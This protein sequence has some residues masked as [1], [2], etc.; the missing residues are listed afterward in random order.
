MLKTSVKFFPSSRKEMEALGWENV[1]IILF[2]GDAY[3]DHPAFG[4]A[5]I[6]RVLESHGYRVA[7][8]PQ[9][10]WRD[11]LRDFKKLGEP[12]LFFGVN[13]GAMDSMVNHYTA[14]KRLRSDDAYTP[15]GLAGMRPDYA[16]KTYSNI[17]KDLYPNVPVVVGGIEASL[18]RLS[19]FDYWQDKIL[20][21]ILVDSKADFLIYGMGERPILKLAKFIKENRKN[22]SDKDLHLQKLDLR[23]IAFLSDIPPIVDDNTLVLHSFK[24]CQ[25]DK[26]AF[27]DNFNNIET[28]A[29]KYN[30]KLIVEPIDNSY[31]Y[32][33]PPFD[34][35]SEQE[36]DSFYDL[37]YTKLPHSRYK[38]KHI[39]AYE[40]IKYSI[41][42]HRGCFGGCS[43]CTIA[44]H[45]GK[46][47][48]SRSEQSILNEIRNLMSL[49]G[50]SGNISDVGGPTANMYGMHG[51]DL[52]IC[53]K[54]FR[55]SCLYP[56][57]CN[58]LNPS[59]RRLLKL[60]ASIS[61][62][63]G[64]KN[65]YVGSG[66]RYDLFLNEKGFLD[67]SSKPYFTEL[68]LNHVSGRLKVAPEH[69]EDRVLNLMNKPSFALFERLRREFD[70]L[71]REK[72][73]K[74]Q[75]IPYFISSHPGCKMQDMEKLSRNLSL[76][77]VLTEQVQDFTPTPMT[78]SS[79]M[80]YT[81]LDMKSL[82]KLY[83]EKNLSKK[84]E[85]KSYFFKK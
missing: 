10:N 65:F 53:E 76:K 69:T 75:L 25:K 9:P 33:N 27:I 72:D 31:V 46:Q 21:S 57:M 32:V 4:T 3:I 20:P 64:I 80:Y 73:L 54:C 15:N 60:Y 11:D 44:A 85:Q 17:L 39:P 13:A 55:K 71:T 38:G 58:N 29:N 30:A 61:E 19:H 7:V 8:V 56:K 42:T 50:F 22:I 5:V 78:K 79:V 41:N 24:Q 36:L 37:P 40:M 12:R 49:E 18:R 45:Q 43:F 34:L 68:V 63:K 23:Q 52:S 62:I 59:H 2:S 51:N 47:I 84:K 16:V 48:Q 70:K 82:E 81:E 28:Q 74:Y 67:S 6:A 26:K 1:D 83:V 14:G 77:G 35:P 66:I